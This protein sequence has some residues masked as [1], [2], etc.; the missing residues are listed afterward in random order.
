[1]ESLKDFVTKEEQLQE[2]ELETLHHQLLNIPQTTKSDPST[3]PSKSM[4]NQ[5]KTKFT[6]E[7]QENDRHDDTSSS[8]SFNSSTDSSDSDNNMTNKLRELLNINNKKHKSKSKSRGFS[9]RRYAKKA[10]SLAT[11]MIKQASRVNFQRLK[12]DNDPRSTTLI[13]MYF[14]E[15]LTNLLDMFH[16]T[17]KILTDYPTINDPTSK[18][19]YA[20]KSLFTLI[21]SYS[22]LEV[23]QIIKSMYGNGCQ[24]LKLLQA[25]CACATPNDAVRHE[26][27]FNTTQIQPNGNCNKIHQTFPKCKTFR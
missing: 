8:D 18:Y 2:K 27:T 12:L 7:K 23:K 16:E 5:R 24:A 10:F 4:S 15:D 21:N 19:D 11:K 20:R 9:K 26:H 17:F 6:S 25:R 14:I 13:F 1:M 3:L 22:N